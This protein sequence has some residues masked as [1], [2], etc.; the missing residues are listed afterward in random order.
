MGYLGFH[1]R[2]R[3][4][5]VLGKYL[6]GLQGGVEGLRG[7]VTAV[8]KPQSLQPTPKVVKAMRS[9]QSPNAPVTS[10]MNLYVYVYA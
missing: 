9:K 7:A 5:V 6:S 8:R 2:N 3:R 10:T 1:V 4:K